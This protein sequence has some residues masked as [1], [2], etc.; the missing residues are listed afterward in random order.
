MVEG[1]TMFPVFKRVYC[2]SNFV[3]NPIK[4]ISIY[5]KIL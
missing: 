3:S 4:A 5:F 1:N 2:S